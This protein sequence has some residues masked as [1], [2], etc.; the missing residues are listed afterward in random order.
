MSRHTRVSRM[1]TV[2]ALVRAGAMWPEMVVARMTIADS[3]LAR[4]PATA[5][6]GEIGTV[7]DI[8]PDDGIRGLLAVSFRNTATGRW[9]EAILVDPTEVS[10]LVR[11]GT[12]N[13]PIRHRRRPAKPGRISWA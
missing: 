4:R 7:E 5:K 13:A 2:H 1:P 11:D 12:A 9:R 6:R 8:L 3:P 10:P